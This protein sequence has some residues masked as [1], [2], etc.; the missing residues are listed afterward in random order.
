MNVAFSFCCIHPYLGFKWGILKMPSVLARILVDNLDERH[1]EMCSYKSL[2][3]TALVYL[4][5]KRVPGLGH[6]KS[7]HGEPQMP[8][9]VADLNLIDTNLSGIRTF[10]KPPDGFDPLTA[11]KEELI[12]H[13]FPLPP[14][15]RRAP[16][17][18][19]HFWR[20]A[21]GRA[22]H[23]VVPNLRVIPDRRRAKSKG[24]GGPGHDTDYANWCGTVVYNP[25][26]T[27]YG[28]YG[29][30][31]IPAVQVPPGD[32]N[33][34]YWSSIWIGLDGGNASGS[35][36][37]LQAGTEQD[38][39]DPSVYEDPNWPFPYYCWYQWYPGSPV[40]VTNFPVTPG[41]TVLVLIT[42]SVGGQGANV[43][44]LNLNSGVFTS[45]VF[46]APGATRLVG[47]SA[48][49]ILEAYPNLLPD[50]G[51]VNM[52]HTFGCTENGDTLVPNGSA[53]SGSFL[54]QVLSLNNNGTPLAEQTET[55]ALHFSDQRTASSD[56]EAS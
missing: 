18:A 10:N 50:F 9:H 51:I 54:T 41:Q 25:T 43:Q 27:A 15:P 42:S 20:M 1:L 26:L 55:T 36:D 14:D 2:G 40:G 24:I 4:S 13:G 22:K 12:R 52:T 29:A 17:Q 6:E 11:S 32:A 28:I 37:C 3:R 8:T 56:T 30:W 38:I 53:G 19:V 44:F 35:Q 21:M 33:F 7:V 5:R 47:D 31:T 45:V 48:E 34:L 39:G 23:H 49:W 16:K 46:F